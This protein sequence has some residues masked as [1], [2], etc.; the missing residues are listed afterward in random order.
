MDRL[1]AMTV[2]LC[3]VEAGS[4][5]A[6]GRKLGMPLA[7][8]SRKLSELEAHLNA[9]LLNRSTRKLDLTDAGRGYVEACKRILGDVEA[10]ERAAAG[11]YEKPQGDLVITA[12]LAL[13]RLHVLPV[14]DEF[15]HDYPDVDVRLVLGDR[16]SRLIDEHVD[17]AVRIGPLPDSR[18][19]AVG[20]G[21]LR[22]VVCASPT[23]LAAHGSPRKPADLTTHRCITFDAL[24][25]ADE[26]SFTTGSTQTRV[27]VHS[28][29]VVNTA[30]A[31]VDAAVAGLGLTRV[32]SYQAEP[33][34]RAQQ[35]AVVLE[36]FEPGPTPVN[37]VFDGQQRIALKLRAFLDF[38]APRLRAGLSGSN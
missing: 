32:L 1:D 16:I 34:R 24:A 28:R 25:S 17:L 30:E 10:A 6:A 38:A 14:I 20:I 35:L 12:P 15:L 8:V 36:K 33:A 13:G 37:L 5:S 23:Y 22:R 7:T 21:A 29:L 4:L 19:V 18:L 31:A 26:W 3:V 9:R 2:F 27:T 11:E